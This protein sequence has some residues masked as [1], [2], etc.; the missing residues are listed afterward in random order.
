[1]T[2]RKRWYDAE[3]EEFARLLHIFKKDF[4]AI[5]ERM[6]KTYTQVRSHYYNLEQK[7]AKAAKIPK[8]NSSKVSSSESLHLIVFDSDSQQ[9]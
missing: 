6:N 8:K 1:M 4:N 5:S 3:N 9:K 2:Y 7:E